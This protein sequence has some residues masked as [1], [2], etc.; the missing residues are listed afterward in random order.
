M[1]MAIVDVENM[2][3]IDW[4]QILENLSDDWHITL[5]GDPEIV[6][7]AIKL[8]CK[9]KENANYIKNVRGANSADF[10]ICFMVGAM[11][12][13]Y[14]TPDE[15]VLIT[16]DHFGKLLNDNLKMLGFPIKLL[17]LDGTTDKDSVIKSFNN[18][19]KNLGMISKNPY[20]SLH[21]HI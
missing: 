14:G 17:D 5:I 12:E 18:Q 9:Y 21:N 7:R 15:I 20:K 3:M 13:R 6:T 16:R 19:I 11:I 10:V 1:K 2:R 4:D 8:H